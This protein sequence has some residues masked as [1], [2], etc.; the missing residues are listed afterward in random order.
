MLDTLETGSWLRIQSAEEWQR[1]D[2]LIK[3]GDDGIIKDLHICSRD[4]VDGSGSLF[5]E[6]GPDLWLLIQLQDPET[7]AVEFFI[8][9]MKKFSWD[10]GNIIEIEAL[11]SAST[12]RLS[13]SPS[14]IDYVVGEEIFYRIAEPP[15]IGPGIFMPT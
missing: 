13:L 5:Y 14:G 11:F 7:P 15:R 10:P 12:V 4:Y 8:R 3:G 9:R 2:E 1:V 6:G